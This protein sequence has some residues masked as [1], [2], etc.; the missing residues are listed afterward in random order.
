[1]KK[2]EPNAYKMLKQERKELFYKFMNYMNEN[3]KGHFGESLPSIVLMYGP[4]A[5]YMYYYGIHP[6]IHTSEMDAIVDKIKDVSVDIEI[7]HPKENRVK[8]AYETANYDRTID[9]AALLLHGKSEVSAEEVKRALQDVENNKY[10]KEQLAKRDTFT[11]F[12]LKLL[13]E[14]YFN[15]TYDKVRK[16]IEKRMVKDFGEGFGE[17]FNKLPKRSDYE[18]Y[19]NYQT[20]MANDLFKKEKNEKVRKLVE[21]LEKKRSR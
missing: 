2:V 20:K 9:V 12:E 8:K 17:N 19:M 13:F 6:E 5:I 14:S 1:M 10:L 21:E 11:I 18:Q 16:M 7:M 3:Y 15:D 4:I